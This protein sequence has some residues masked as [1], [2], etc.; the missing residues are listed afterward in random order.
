MLVRKIDCRLGGLAECIVDRIVGHTDDREAPR[1]RLYAAADGVRAIQVAADK[2]LIHDGLCGRRLISHV[3][4]VV[5][6]EE[7]DGHHLKVSGGD[8][9]G[10]GSILPK[11]CAYLARHPET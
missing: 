3:G 7:R 10:N 6:L 2:L 9:G 5:S 4:K 8:S 1:A 11:F